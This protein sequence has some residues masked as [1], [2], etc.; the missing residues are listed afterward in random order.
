MGATIII[1]YAQEGTIFVP[2]IPL[3]S[4]DHSFKFKQLVSSENVLCNDFK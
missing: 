2:R 4:Y 3:I 1:G